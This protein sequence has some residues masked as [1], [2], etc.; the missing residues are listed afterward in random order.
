M[1]ANDTSAAW[2]EVLRANDIGA[3]VCDNIDALR[4]AYVRTPDGT[5]GIDRGSY[6]F[7]VYED[8][9]SGHTVTQLDPFAV[10]PSRAAVNMMDPA[11][12]YGSSTR[13]VLKELGYT[14]TE[15]DVMLQNGSIS[16]TWSKE[17]LPS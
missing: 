2:L 12:K 5:P 8:H 11:E 17:Y 7:S 14:E 10:R 9:P 3:A 15:I 16:E 1:F 4:A 13:S 6:S